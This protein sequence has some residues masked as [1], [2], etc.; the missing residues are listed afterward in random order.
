MSVR[1]IKNTT[2]GGPTSGFHYILWLHSM[3][4]CVWTSISR[5]PTYEQ[6]WYTCGMRYVKEGGRILFV[7]LMQLTFLL[8][9]AHTTWLCLHCLIWLILDSSDLTWWYSN[10]Y[11]QWMCT[12]QIYT[13]WCQYC[14]VSVVRHWIQDVGRSIHSCLCCTL[15][16]GSKWIFNNQ[17]WANGHSVTSTSLSCNCCFQ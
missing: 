12:S 15:D 10:M 17:S 11:V 9:P 13:P 5:M 6:V 2:F 8:L 1:T 4:V 14:V 3:H 7:Y 16:R